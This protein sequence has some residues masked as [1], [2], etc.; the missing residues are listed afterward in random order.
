MDVAIITGTSKGLGESL[1]KQMIQKGVSVFGIARHENQSLRNLAQQ[2][3]VFYEHIVCDLGN[4]NMIQGTVEQLHQKLKKL[5]VQNLTLINNA[6]VLEPI[7][8]A[9]EID[10]K[11]L[12]FH[13]DVNLFAPMY[14]TNAFLRMGKE[15]EIRVLCLQIT[16]GAGERP[17]YGWSAY[18]S[19]K[20]ALNMYT[21]TVAKEQE[22]LRTG[23]QVIAF[24]PG[25]M[26][27]EMQKRI[28][29][30]DDEQFIDVN[31]FRKYYEKNQLR[32]TDEVAKVI[33]NLLR[34]E[35][36]KNGKIYSIRDY[37]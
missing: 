8:H 17:V 13:L 11:D 21:K 34:N 5:T 7:H 15:E 24:S 10:P 26:D 14:L 35:E 9:M 20:A 12:K 18:C 36:I 27:T 29:E 4:S 1:A 37:L 22:A 3:D 19:S 6:A 28:R 16:S 31:Q 32:T 23:H 33:V 30:S 2:K 25:V